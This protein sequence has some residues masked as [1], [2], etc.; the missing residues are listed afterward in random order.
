MKI[1]RWLISLLTLL[2]IP[3]ALADLGQTF[4]NVFDKIVI[5]GNLSF[6]GLPNDFVLLGVTRILIWILAFTIFFGVLTAVGKSGKALGFLDRRQGMVVALVI[7]TIAS[8]FMPAELLLAT[9]T[10]WATA[11][12]LILIGGPIVGIAFLLWK[13]PWDGKETRGTL[14]LK[15]VICFVLFWILSVMRHHVGELI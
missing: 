10:G 8:I 7:A 12:T 9:G 15:L 11:F 5:I 13:I 1:K 14:F 2:S 4:H 6:L 3:M